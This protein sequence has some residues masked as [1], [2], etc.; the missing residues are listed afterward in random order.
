MAEC[1][2]QEEVSGFSVQ[3][4]SPCQRNQNSHKHTPQTET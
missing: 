4:S 1:V 3:G 2:R